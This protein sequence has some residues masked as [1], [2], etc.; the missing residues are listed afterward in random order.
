MGYLGLEMRGDRGCSVESLSGQGNTPIQPHAPPRP[1]NTPP[2]FPHLFSQML[3]GWKSVQ[4]TKMLG[5]FSSTPAPTPAP[6]EGDYN[7]E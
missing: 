6:T 7:T 4:H 2:T 3:I 1:I 5:M